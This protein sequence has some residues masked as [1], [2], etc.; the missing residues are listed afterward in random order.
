M[1]RSFRSKALRHFAERGDARK[2]GVQNHD[3]V[4]QILALLDAATGPRDMDQP[5][6][7][8]HQLK[9]SLRWSVRATGNWRITFA[10][11]GKDAVDVDL[12]DYH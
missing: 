3:R 11:L 5:G 2:L 9:Q 8:C 7:H 4:R 10:F 12:E 6:L 1:I